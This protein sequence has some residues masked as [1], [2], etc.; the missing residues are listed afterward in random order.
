[1]NIIRIILL[2]VALLYGIVMLVRNKLFDW[3]ILPVS[4][5]RIPVISVG[6]LSM[7]GSGKTP[8]VEYIVNL[9][10]DK[11]KV[12]TLSR[13]YGR[14]TKGFIEANEDS[15]YLQIGDEPLQYK[16]K[17][18]DQVVAVD[19]CRSRG[20]KI[21]SNTINDL[22]VVVLDDAFQ[23]RWIKPGLSVLLTDFHKLYPQDYVFPTGTLREFRRGSKRADIIVVTKT[24]CVF[25]PITRR[26]LTDVIKPAKDQELYFSFI[27][28]KPLRP[29][30]GIKIEKEKKKFNTIL[31]FCGIANS[32]P[33]QEHLKTRCQELIVLEFPDHHKYSIKDLQ[34][35][36]KTYDDIFSA[37]KAIVTTEK[38]TMRL[39]KTDLIEYMQDYPVYYV[40]IEVKIHKDD[41]K[42][43]DEQIKTYVERNKRDI[44]VPSEE[45]RKQA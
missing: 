36:I 13:G 23:H 31:M 35:V 1:M 8:H 30:P 37:N 41:S 3:K 34:K 42:K 12:A 2:P 10:K 4:S 14:N 16:Q 17:F 44:E 25:S 9:L 38:D 18:E 45:N 43:F 21:L 26:R 15:D 5:F 29:V 39:I 7:G 32:Y 20:I 6:N 19:A 24:P 40:P 22:G 11:Y 33:L 27:T 28:Y